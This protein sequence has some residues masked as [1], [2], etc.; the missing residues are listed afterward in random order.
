[1]WWFEQTR[2]DTRLIS[3]L[4]TMCSRHLSRSLIVLRLRKTQT[5]CLTS[6]LLHHITAHSESWKPGEEYGPRVLSWNSFLS[7]ASMWLRILFPSHNPNMGASEKTCIPEN[8]TKRWTVWSVGR[9]R[10]Q[11]DVVLR[12]FDWSSAITIPLNSI[13]DAHVTS[14]HS[15]NICGT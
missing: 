6:A 5:N 11:Y 7:S 15:L 2:D 14:R 12:R 9:W 1:M 4:Q 8:Q 10:S 3:A 13:P